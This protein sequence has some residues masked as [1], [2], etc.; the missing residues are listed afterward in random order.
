MANASLTMVPH[1]SDDWL[2]VVDPDQ[3]LML[4]TELDRILH[5]K[6]ERQRVRWVQAGG[7]A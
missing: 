1:P 7:H 3:L 5:E 4:L 6:D 2:F